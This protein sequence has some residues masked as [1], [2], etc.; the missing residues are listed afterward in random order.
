IGEGLQG[1]ER[2]RG[3]DHERCRRIERIDGVLERRAVDVR[4]EADVVS[5]IAAPERIDEESRSEHRTANANVQDAGQ[6]AE[7]AALEGIDQSAHTLSAG[8]GKVDLVRRSAPTFRDVSRGP[9]LAR[10]DYLTGEKSI[11]SS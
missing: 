6:I 1:R 3:D 7:G 2:L 11:A 4:Q 5:G 9:V 10:V 8:S